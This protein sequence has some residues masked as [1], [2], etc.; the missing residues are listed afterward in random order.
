MEAVHQQL[1]VLNEEVQELATK[2]D[3]ACDAWM[4]D[5]EN[6]VLK[7]VYNDLKDMK[8]Q[9]EERRKALEAM[10]TTQRWVRSS[11]HAP[12]HEAIA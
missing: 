4:Q 5:Q 9:L 6:K 2:L 12:S 10:L 3:P 11:L 7:Q 8:S 1:V